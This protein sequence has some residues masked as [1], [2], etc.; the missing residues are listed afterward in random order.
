MAILL[1]ETSRVLVQGI[2]GREGGLRTQLMLEY[3]TRIMAGVTPGRGG[4][5]VD[6]VPV[7]DTV[8][9]AWIAHGPFDISVIFVPAPL[10]CH[11]A[12]EAI[13]AGLKLVVLIPDRVPLY[14]VMELAEFAAGHR[15][16]F[17]GP[18]TVGLV[19]PGRALL[20][21]MGGRVETAREYY[22]RG[23]V[24]IMSRSGGITSAAAYALTKAGIGQSTAVHVG[25]D[26]IVGLGFPDLLPLFQADD[27]TEAVVM[28]GEIG[29]TQEERA[30]NLVAAGQFTKPLI[31]FIGGAA[32]REGTRFSHAGAIV[33][34][35]Q[36]RHAD[37]VARLR[38]AGAHIVSSVEEIAPLVKELLA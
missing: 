14:D 30:A 23:S 24:G 27:Q 12:L 6:G 17:V 26:P 33:E 10:A 2:T 11:A 22:L 7:F 38:E 36:G 13:E 15:A 1:D 21:M 20:G 32:A 18:N 28:Y 4:R 8:R 25:G 37:K 34:G 31:C 35:G 3:G 5:A 16:Q 29:T 9:E 19:S